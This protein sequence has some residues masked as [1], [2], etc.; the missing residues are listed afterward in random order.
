MALNPHH[1]LF[2]V[3]FFTFLSQLAEAQVSANRPGTAE[4]RQRITEI[5]R[6][7]A[8][9]EYA[10]KQALDEAEPVRREHQRAEVERRQCLRELSLARRAAEE[11]AKNSPETTAARSKVDELKAQWKVTAA[12]NVKTLE[13]N[14]AEYQGLLR[15]LASAKEQRKSSGTRPPEVRKTQ[16]KQTAALEQKRRDRED[17]E[18][19]DDK[20]AMTLKQRLKD[21]EM[22]LDARI[23]KNKKAVEKDDRLVSAKARIRRV[24]D[25]LN[26]AKQKLLQ[27]EANVNR[28]R[29]NLQTLVA[30]RAT[31]ESQLQELTAGIV[32]G[33]QYTKSGKMIGS[34]KCGRCGNSVSIGAARCHNCGVVFQGTVER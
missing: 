19:A 1:S 18:L 4:I 34:A 21:A 11:A 5:N 33:P 30:H 8:T 9:G 28:I 10:L 29:S 12:R 27:A 20:E 23:K 14:N 15:S 16:A 17:I 22:E 6:L 24:T 13:Q 26:S 2:V 25:E 7:L 32:L 3:A 31:Q